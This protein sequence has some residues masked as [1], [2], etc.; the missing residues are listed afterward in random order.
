MDTVRLVKP[1]TETFLSVEDVRRL[2]S[3]TEPSRPFNSLHHVKDGPGRFQSLNPSASYSELYELLA[4][5]AVCFSLKI[6]TQ[7][8]ENDIWATLQADFSVGY[9]NSIAGWIGRDTNNHA[10][11]KSLQVNKNR[12]GVLAA[13][14]Q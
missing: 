11:R 12:F 8:V 9:L 4:N 13:R 2:A 6:G 3:D 7:P 5:G 1:L 14:N 10:Q